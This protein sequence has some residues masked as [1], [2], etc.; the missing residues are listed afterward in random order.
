[1]PKNKR[2][3]AI[4][5]VLLASVGILA[6]GKYAE[7]RI[8]QERPAEIANLKLPNYPSPMAAMQTAD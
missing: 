3:T 4:G 6:L 1:M 5:C 2:H 7:S 8:Y